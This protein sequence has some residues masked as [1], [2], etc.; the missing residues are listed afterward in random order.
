MTPKGTP[1]SV[2]A[3]SS[4]SGRREL[5]PSL[6]RKTHVKR[7]Q[8]LPPLSTFPLFL[9]SVRTAESQTNPSTPPLREHFHLTHKLFTPSSPS[10]TTSI[11]QSFLLSMK[12]RLLMSRSPLPWQEQREVRTLLSTMKNHTNT[13]TYVASKIEVSVASIHSCP[14]STLRMKER[15]FTSLSEEREISSS[16]C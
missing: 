9:T 10:S 11:G 14:L 3:L 15:E 13:F 5:S 4:P 8:E 12:N 6:D 16:S 7:K 2:L 1:S